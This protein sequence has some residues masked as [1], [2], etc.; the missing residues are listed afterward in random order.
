MLRRHISGTITRRAVASRPKPFL[1]RQRFSRHELSRRV[2]AVSGK[3]PRRVPAQCR[4]PVALHDS[5]RELLQ[6]ERSPRRGNPRRVSH[7]V[8]SLEGGDQLTELE[9][10]LG[11]ALL[12]WA[13]EGNVV[14]ALD[15][16]AVEEL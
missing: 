11:L 2:P 13:V 6:R 14:N 9:D 10:E 1:G 7:P 4:A 8:R 5:R 15:E 12:G 3:V 16:A